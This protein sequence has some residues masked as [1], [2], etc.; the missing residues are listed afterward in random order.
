VILAK[1]KLLKDSFSEKQKENS[2]TLQI[3]KLVTDDWE[4]IKDH[5]DPVAVLLV[6]KRNIG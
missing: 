2:R 6:P 3:L 5:L 1:C 4:M